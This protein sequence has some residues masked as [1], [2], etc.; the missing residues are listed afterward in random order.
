MKIAVLCS[1][2]GSNLQAIIDGVKSGYIPA[3]IALVVSDRKDAYALVRAREAGVY[4]LALSIGDFKSREDFDR[5]IMKNLKARGVDLVVLAGYMRLLSPEFIR[6]YSDR[7]INIHPAL[8]PSFKGTHAIRD[9]LK[10]G[11][12]VT[13]VTVHF[14]D[15]ELDN[16]PVILQKAVDIRED[17]NEETLLERVH[18]EEHKLYPEAIKL[19]AEGK[20]KIDGRRVAR[21]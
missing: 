5:E 4:R 1:G 3:E 8:L 15:E 7:V 12:K 6:E 16:G 11:V 10:Y 21:Q 9:A 20:L 19:F 13:G 14:V 18:K 17:D 2:N